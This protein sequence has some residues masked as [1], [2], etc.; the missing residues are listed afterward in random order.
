MKEI[1]DRA[2]EI[3]REGQRSFGG[4]VIEYLSDSLK[5]AWKEAKEG[6]KIVSLSK[7][8][9]DLNDVGV[10]RWTAKEWKN[11]GKHRI[12]VQSYTNGGCARGNDGYYEVVD[13]V[14][15]SKSVSMREAAREV[16]HKYQGY[17]L[18]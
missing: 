18:A 16:F 5:M 12:Y 9:A 11:Y 10:S 6:K 15:A 7:I 17:K 3:A 14:I 4:K 8:V 1:M 2:W 13:G